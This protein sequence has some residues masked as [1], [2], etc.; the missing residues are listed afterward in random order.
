[1][2]V[3]RLQ[4]IL[5]WG[6][7]LSRVAQLGLRQRQVECPPHIDVRYER[8]GPRQKSEEL[9]CLRMLWMSLSARL[10]RSWGF[11]VVPTVDLHALLTFAVRCQSTNFVKK[12]G[13][14]WID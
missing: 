5:V 11:P 10:R 14:F 8:A 3:I 4:Q 7:L 13:I 12:G 9:V 2:L 1:M 6:P